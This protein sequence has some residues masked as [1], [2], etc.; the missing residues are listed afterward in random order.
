MNALAQKLCQAQSHMLKA[1]STTQLYLFFVFISFLL[2]AYIIFGGT[3][4]VSLH[5]VDTVTRVQNLNEAVCIWHRVNSIEKVWIQ[6]FSLQLWINSRINFIAWCLRL[7]IGECRRDQVI[8]TPAAHESRFVR[9]PYYE[10]ALSCTLIWLEAGKIPSKQDLLQALTEIS[11][12]IE[13]LEP[14]PIPNCYVTSAGA[15]PTNTILIWTMTLTRCKQI[16]QWSVWEF[17]WRNGQS[18]GSAASK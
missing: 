8:F 3:H 16:L 13:Q 9:C 2:H 17:P 7:P 6:L 4:S 10:M 11:K 5:E 15:T 18:A 12:C 14:H 1:L